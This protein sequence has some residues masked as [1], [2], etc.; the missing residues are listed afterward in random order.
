MAGHLINLCE[1]NFV[2]FLYGKNENG[3][4]I[5]S[6]RLHFEIIYHV[7]DIALHK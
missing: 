3:W 2:L 1:I 7:V 4:M 6:V 5:L